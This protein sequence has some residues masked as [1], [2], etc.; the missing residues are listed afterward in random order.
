MGSREWLILR[1]HFLALVEV[2]KSLYILQRPHGEPPV[3]PLLHHVTKKVKVIAVGKEH[4][5]EPHRVA[6]GVEMMLKGTD[7]KTTNQA[8]MQVALI[9][10]ILSCS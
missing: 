5:M 1:K 8:P 2:Q 9:N 10:E 3:L 6:A 4:H 7:V